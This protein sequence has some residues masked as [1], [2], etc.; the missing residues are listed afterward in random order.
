MIT[1]LKIIVAGIV[2]L[3]ASLAFGQVEVNSELHL[4]LA[5]KDSLLFNVAFNSCNTNVLEEIFTEDF[6]FYHD[7]GGLTEGRDAF[8]NPMKENCAQRITTEMQPSKRILIANSL[9]VYPLYKNGELY[10]AIQHGIHRFESLDKDNCYQ[11]GD[12]AKFTHVWV[13][14]NLVWKVKRELSYNHQYKQ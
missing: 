7:K 10:G 14:E 5:Q 8:L 6:E 11:R 4:L 9:E 1:L 13:K 3:F 12:I 2:A